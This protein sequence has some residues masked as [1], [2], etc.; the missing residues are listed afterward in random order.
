MDEKARSRYVAL[1]AQDALRYKEEH[2]RWTEID[3]SSYE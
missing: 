3:W 1:S 2:K